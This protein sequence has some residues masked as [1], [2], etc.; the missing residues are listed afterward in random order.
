[1]RPSVSRKYSGP[2]ATL[3]RATVA[4]TTPA[5]G[6]PGP[7]LSLDSGQPRTAT[8][9]AAALVRRLGAVRRV[10][11]LV[12]APLVRLAVSTGDRGSRM[13]FTAL[14]VA[15]TVLTADVRPTRIA[16]ETFQ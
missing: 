6:S 15:A 7:R 11:A 13:A 4:R 8:T 5:P 14:S 2:L 10:A 12:V 1:M 9:A 16:L 3:P